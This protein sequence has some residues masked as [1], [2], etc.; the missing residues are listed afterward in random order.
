MSLSPLIR[1]WGRDCTSEGCMLASHMLV[2]ALVGVVSALLIFCADMCSLHH[3]CT[4]G[5]LSSDCASAA[6]RREQRCVAGSGLL[7]DATFRAWM[8]WLKHDRDGIFLREPCLAFERMRSIP[9]LVSRNWS[10][11]LEQLCALLHVCVRVRMFFCVALTGAEEETILM[12]PECART[13]HRQLTWA[14]V[15]RVGRI[16]AVNLTVCLVDAGSS[17]VVL[18]FV[19]FTERLG[20]RCVELVDLFGPFEI[21]AIALAQCSDRDDRADGPGQVCGTIQ[22]VEPM[23]LCGAI[24]SFDLMALFGNFSVQSHFE[25]AQSYFEMSTA[26]SYKATGDFGDASA[27]LRSR[28]VPEA[29]VPFDP[30]NLF[31]RQVLRRLRSCVGK[32][33]VL[34]CRHWFVCW[35]A[36]KIQQFS[37]QPLML[38]QSTCRDQRVSR[39]RARSSAIHLVDNMCMLVVFDLCVVEPRLAHTCLEPSV[40][41]LGG[42]RVNGREAC[43]G[44]RV[45]ASR[46]QDK[47][48]RKGYSRPDLKLWQSRGSERASAEA[49]VERDGSALWEACRFCDSV[50]FELRTWAETSRHA[51]VAACD[52]VALSGLRLHPALLAK[53]R[54]PDQLRC[55]MADVLEANEGVEPSE[56]WQAHVWDEDVVDLPALSL[57]FEQ[58]F[59]CVLGWLAC[60][61]V[62]ES[63]V[64]ESD[65]SLLASPVRVLDVTVFEC[66]HAFVGNVRSCNQ[67]SLGI[68][69]CHVLLGCEWMSLFDRFGVLFGDVPGLARKQSQPDRWLELPMDDTLGTDEPLRRQHFAERC[70]L[71]AARCR[72]FV[73]A[74]V[75]F[76]LQF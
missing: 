34:S 71:E 16:I 33:L 68:E 66:C 61:G 64:L 4:W 67:A 43:L 35:G 57:V 21:F 3:V 50:L 36:R 32:R 73:P 48:L 65:M 60:V 75:G 8:V 27:S 6:V 72:M 49:S 41:Y 45:R 46:Q 47:E 12:F 1:A 23:A 58:R 22:L 38:C 39:N 24:E 40:S 56:L 28:N 25:T 63:Q 30:W 11:E 5:G 10:I 53:Q 20:A 17:E 52:W 51:V 26:G 19:P 2:R 44:L 69:V 70:L 7:V 31:V 9:S 42:N 18:C 55:S 74:H 76:S 13:A 15:S 59:E 62:L 54:T 29:F 14:V 37:F